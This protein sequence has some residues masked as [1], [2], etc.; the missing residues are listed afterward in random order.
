MDVLA[1]DTRELWLMQSRD[2]AAEPPP[3]DAARARFVLAVHA[4][5]GAGCRQFLAAAA[6]SYGA[7]RDTARA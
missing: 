5:H 7:Y 4:G 6:F 1:P 3:L 2:C